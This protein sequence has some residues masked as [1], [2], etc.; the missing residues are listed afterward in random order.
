M[1]LIIALFAALTIAGCSLFAPQYAD[2]PDYQFAAKV[3]DQV[4]MSFRTTPGGQP[5]SMADKVL[6]N[7]VFTG[8]YLTYVHTAKDMLIRNGADPDDVIIVDIKY[9]QPVSPTI[10]EMMRGYD[11]KRVVYK[12]FVLDCDYPYVYQLGEK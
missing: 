9:K 8:N 7:D 3:H 10:Q 4:M 11:H 6:A 1:K 5:V 12:G 2:N